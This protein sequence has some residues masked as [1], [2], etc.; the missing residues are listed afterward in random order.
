M[1]LSQLANLGEFVG[2]IAVL[3]TLIYLALQVRHVKQTVR[4]AALDETAKAWRESLGLLMNNL[5]LFLRGAGA[6]GFARLSGSETLK[7]YLMV[8]QLFAYFENF[9]SKYHDG[10]I[11]QVEW[12]RL[13]RIIVYYLAWPGMVDWWPDNRAM[14]TEPFA[15]HVAEIFEGLQD[16]TIER[17]DNDRLL[18]DART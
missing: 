11:D 16:G 18:R 7:F 15:A 14:Y 4:N 5:D 8:N 1:D 10:T 9:F 6:A 3:V 13:N 2:G 12:E 17:P